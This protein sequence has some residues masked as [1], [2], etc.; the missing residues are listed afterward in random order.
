MYTCLHAAAGLNGNLLLDLARSFSPLIELTSTNTVVMDISGLGYIFGGPQDI[1]CHALKLADGLKVHI[2]VAVA[3][4]PDVVVLVALTLDGITVLE[5]GEERSFLSKLP[6][7]ALKHFLDEINTGCQTDPDNRQLAQFRPDN[8]RTNR[9]ASK[10][11]IDRQAITPERAEEMFQTL[12]LWGIA[13]L[14]DLAELPPDGIAETLGPDGLLLQRLAR[15]AN[16]RALN[17]LEERPVFNESIDLESPIEL[18][19]QLT[20]VISGIMHRLCLRLAGQGFATNEI[21]LEATMERNIPY[22]RRLQLPFPMSGAHWLS[23]LL[24]IDVESHPPPGPLNAITLSASPVRP[25]MG[26]QGLFD[27][28]SPE[29]EKIELTIAR[30]ARLVGRQN[31]GAIEVDDDHKPESFRLK[32]FSITKKA[33]P[34]AKSRHLEKSPDPSPEKSPGPSPDQRPLTGFKVFRPPIPARIQLKTAHFGFLKC[35][36]VTPPLAGRIVWQSGPW[37]ASGHWWS[38]SEHWAREEWD[39][40]LADGTLCRIFR[41]PAPVPLSQDDQWYVEGIYD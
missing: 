23:R 37:S 2:N 39:I 25:R 4:N 16:Q 18:I 9:P 32:S 19:E 17:Y 24:A 6:L 30:L 34:L 5:Q 11:S 26:Q 36:A 8:I 20:F 35:Q 7:S 1:A 21:I 40:A 22:Q 3:A 41:I 14:G 13:T 31:V 28:L 27:R 29:P 12:S 15:G 10:G 38:L 33:R